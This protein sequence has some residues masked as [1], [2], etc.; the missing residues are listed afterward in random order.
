MI[1]III[2]TYEPKEYLHDCLRAIKQQDVDNFHVL[3]V[4]NGEKEPYYNMIELLLDNLNLNDICTLTYTTKKG[5]SAARNIG[6][7]FASQRGG[8]VVFIDDD[9]FISPNYI[10][11]LSA[12]LSSIDMIVLSNWR[13]FDENNKEFYKDYLSNKFLNRKR[14]EHRNSLYYH[15]SFL[16]TAC[17]K[18]IPVEAIS[19]S[20]FDESIS[21]GEDSLF[22]ACISARIKR[23]LYSEEDVYY[24]RRVRQGSASRNKKAFILKLYNSI[25]LSLKYFKIHIS[26]PL[27][28]D[29]LFFLTRYVAVFKNLFIRK[30]F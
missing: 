11:S 17:G 12:K 1:T 6:I 29:T 24:F 10:R 27:K 15:R 7:D 2:P 25:R 26:S 16:S 3:I 9:D 13:N 21:N 30:L 22:M 23:V 18:I 14:V 5:V 20:R 8:S 19:D 28:V 4:L